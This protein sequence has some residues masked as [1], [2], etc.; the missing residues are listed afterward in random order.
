MTVAPI[1]KIGDMEIAVGA[2]GAMLLAVVVMQLLSLLRWLGGMVFDTSKKK[3]LERD[4]TL[5]ELALSMR[6]LTSDV[7]VMKLTMLKE[8]QV[9]KTIHYEMLKADRDRRP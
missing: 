1:G 9:I 2:N 7:N 5:E 8:E 4:K 6:Q 3:E